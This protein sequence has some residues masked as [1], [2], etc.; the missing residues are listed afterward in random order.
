M[1]HNPR[2]QTVQKEL[3]AGDTSE[4]SARGSEDGEV[5]DGIG[6]IEYATPADESSKRHHSSLLQ[7]TASL[8]GG[9][10]VE[11]PADPAGLY[12]VYQQSAFLP[13]IVDAFITNVYRTGYT[14]KPV[15]DLQNPE[16]IT[17][18]RTALEW[19]KAQGDID[20]TPNVTDAE[21]NAA[22][23]KYRKRAA[24]EAQLI[25][26]YV[27]TSPVG[28]SW[29]TLWEYTGQDLEITGNAYWE[30]LR[31]SSQAR[32]PARLR[33]VPSITM[34]VCPPPT[35]YHVVKDRVR[36][37][38]FEWKDVVNHKRFVKYVQLSRTQNQTIAAYFKEYGDPR[39][40]SRKTGNY[41]LTLLDLYKA[42]MGVDLESLREQ[43]VSLDEI[44][45][46]AMPLQATEILHH[47]QV[48]GLSDLY[49]WPRWDGASPSIIGA[50]ELDEENLK[51][52]KDESIPQLLLL[53][54]G[55][56]IGQK[57]YDRMVSSI[58]SRK[59]GRKGMLILEANAASKL[60]GGPS[61]QP[62]IHVEKLKTEQHSDALFLNYEKRA[63]EKTLGVFRMPRS[64][65][66]KDLGSNKSTNLTTAR[67][68]QNQVYGPRR[69]NFVNEV[70]NMQILSDLGVCCWEYHANALQPLDPELRATII[71]TLIEKGVITIEESRKLAAPIFNESLAV[72]DNLWSKM[73]PRVLTIMLQTKNKEIAS[74]LLG[75]DTDTL[76]QIAMAAEATIGIDTSNT[77]E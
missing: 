50:R 15:I 65:L 51:N 21:V 22:V 38:L 45:R 42:E 31:S 48:Y 40:M 9:T 47:M 49:G 76:S 4:I 35:Q 52:V 2:R 43:G 63:E 75:N 28:M 61:V 53:I 8:D 41:Y 59:N 25:K 66:G 10:Y 73:P 14:L 62:S 18:I 17:R 26:E 6:F 29:D 27:Q 74:A 54:G 33:W 64:E 13:A 67:F 44:K 7:S 39:I 12:T 30:V 71:G 56:V 70:M 55:G 68:A 72:L 57:S 11:P 77:T 36:T 32:R 34:R 37:G 23:E 19:A 5:V 16:A 69:T 20:A 46:M 3:T 1:S 58:R 60:P 24:L